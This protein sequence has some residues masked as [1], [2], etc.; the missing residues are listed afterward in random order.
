[1]R[2]L[3]FTVA[4]YGRD[5]RR[6]MQKNHQV[7]EQLKLEPFS[8]F[9]QDHEN[10]VIKYKA[11]THNDN[12]KAISGKTIECQRLIPSKCYLDGCIVRANQLNNVHQGT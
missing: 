12:I 3:L 1:M 9:T 4:G 10:N 2:K 7:I 11:F 5:S 6:E 8:L